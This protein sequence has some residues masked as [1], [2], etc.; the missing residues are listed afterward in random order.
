MKE[1]QIDINNH[2]SLLMENLNVQKQDKEINNNCNN[3]N[4][5]VIHDQVK[6]LTLNLHV[7]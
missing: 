3:N 4:K 1:I 7:K 5:K 2:N 6:F